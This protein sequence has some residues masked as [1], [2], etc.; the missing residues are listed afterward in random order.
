MAGWCGDVASGGGAAAAAAGPDEA[1]DRNPGLAI[2]PLQLA[3]VIYTSGSTGPPKA[4]LLAHGGLANTARA[5]AAALRVTAG[6]RLLQF[7]SLNFDAA[8][9]EIAQAWSAGARLCLAPPSSQGASLGLLRL[10]RDQGVTTATLPP[11]LLETLPEEDLPALEV[12]VVAGEACPAEL[13]TRWGRWRRFL[14]AYG[15][16][17]V[18][19]CA[20]VA[21]CAAGTGRPPIGRPIA[22]VR[23]YVLGPDLQPAPIGCSGEIYVGGAGVGRGYGQAPDL[24]AGRFVP[25]PFGGAPGGRLYRTGDLARWLQDGNLDFRGRSDRQ[26]KVRGFRIELGEVEATLRLHPAVGACAVTVRAGRGGDPLLAAYVAPRDGAAAGG[27]ELRTFLRRSLP[28]HMVP[29]SFTALASLPVNLSGK[30]DLRALPDPEEAAH[31]RDTARPQ[32]PRGPIEELL[33]EIFAG[34]LRRERVEVE[35]NFFDLGGHSLLATQ[36]VSR[37][38]EA[39]RVELTLRDLFEA[40]TVSGLA[41]QVERALRGDTGAAPLP[42]PLL[43]VPRGDP[44]PRGAAYGLR[45]CGG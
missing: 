5:M 40:P 33:A 4:V 44:P 28:E 2:D 1:R 24:T 23:V 10:C 8:I 37:A 9:C 21:A 19:V 6:K 30:V 16:T 14:N 27:D 32:Q 34:L 15:P 26:V 31:H 13:P 22:N 18:T 12:L 42:P 36:V 7:A 38:C 20:A 29:Q 43:P 25:D 41:V 35:D 45:S 11:S 3:Y 39:F 17:E